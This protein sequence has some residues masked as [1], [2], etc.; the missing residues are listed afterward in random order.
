MDLNFEQVSSV[1]IKVHVH[2]PKLAQFR[3]IFLGKIN[4]QNL[5]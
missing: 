4:M 3:V 5:D 1:K 2:V